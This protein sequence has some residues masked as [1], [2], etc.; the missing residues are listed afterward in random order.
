MAADAF[1]HVCGGRQFF[2]Q[3]LGEPLHGVAMPLRQHP[4]QSTG[5]GLGGPLPA[6][7]WEG[8]RGGRGGRAEAPLGEQGHC[9]QALTTRGFI[10]I[11]ARLSASCAA[12]RGSPSTGP[13]G[14]RIH[15]PR[16]RP[17]ARERR[18]PHAGAETGLYP[19]RS[20]SGRPGSAAGRTQVSRPA[21]RPCQGAAGGPPLPGRTAGRGRGPLRTAVLRAW[22]WTAHRACGGGAV[23]AHGRRAASARRAGQVGG[24]P[25]DRPRVL[26]PRA[27]RCASWSPRAVPRF[28]SG[29]RRRGARRYHR[30]GTALSPGAAACG[31]RHRP[32]LASRWRA[33]TARPAASAARPQPGRAGRAWPAWAPSGWVGTLRQRGHLPQTQATGDP[34][35]SSLLAWLG[36]SPS[37][38]PRWCQVADSSPARCQ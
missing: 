7:G 31:R 34:A 36:Q 17:A 4:S 38:W 8:R 2:A 19:P 12:H 16:L 25:A 22:A 10:L 21:R 24:S 23:P 29:A 14:A 3:W 18:M 11:A 28:W 27:W 6:P 1:G 13:C 20:T 26:L 9:G 30:G 5:G 15:R 37:S 33:D 35:A 32:G